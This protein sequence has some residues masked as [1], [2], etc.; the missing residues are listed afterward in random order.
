MKI[1]TI[2]IGKSVEALG[3]WNKGSL[4][5]ELGEGDDVF[6]C[7]KALKHTLDAMLPS[8][9]GNATQWRDNNGNWGDIAGG[10]PYIVKSPAP[11]ESRLQS[12][13]HD[14]ST[15]TE[16]KVLESY[17]LIVSKNPELQEIYNSKIKELS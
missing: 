8:V 12:I 5:A 7:W 13:S 14:I 11:K 4:E 1:T 10:T 6:D 3:E 17:R 16:L 9:N 2:S 15:C